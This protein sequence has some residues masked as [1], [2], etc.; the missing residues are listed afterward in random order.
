MGEVATPLRLSCLSGFQHHLGDHLYHCR[1]P[2]PL[3]P[4][5][6]GQHLPMHVITS[7]SNSGSTIIA[8]IVLRKVDDAT[9]RRGGG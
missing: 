4:Y 7:P 1:S 2:L 6:S 8:V 5:G 3:A 9:K